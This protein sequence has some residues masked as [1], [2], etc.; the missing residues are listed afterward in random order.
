MSHII[1]LVQP[2][3]DPQ[4]R[5]YLDFSNPSLAWDAI[6]RL[7]EERLKLLTPGV[8]KITYDVQQLFL[9]LDNLS[10]ISCMV[11]VLASRPARRALPLPPPPPCAP[12]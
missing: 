9:Y 4:T 6:V 12:F 8:Q 11:C 1:L 2:S 5:T 10:D 7:F 3:D